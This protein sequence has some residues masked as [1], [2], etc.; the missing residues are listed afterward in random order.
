MRDIIC[1]IPHIVDDDPLGQLTSFIVSSINWLK[2]TRNIFFTCH[3]YY[4]QSLDYPY[5]VSQQSQFPMI[6]R[7]SQSLQDWL[8]IHIW[9]KMFLN[10]GTQ[11]DWII[12]TKLNVR[13]TE[14]SGHTNI[15]VLKVMIM[16]IITV[17][18]SFE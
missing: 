1:F 18:L 3:L 12:K 4:S 7:G 15:A 16:L 13:R 5:F 17:F 10:V 8:L 6:E 11:K 2:N 9:M 14:N